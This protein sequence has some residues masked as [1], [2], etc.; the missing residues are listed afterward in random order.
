MIWA[1]LPAPMLISAEKS[2]FFTNA[3]DLINKTVMTV[4]VNYVVK[5]VLNLIAPESKA[6]RLFEDGIE[7]FADQINGIEGWT[8]EQAGT[9]NE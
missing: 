1:A 8:E 3:T 6:A 5:P 2:R 9:G 7:V 4:P